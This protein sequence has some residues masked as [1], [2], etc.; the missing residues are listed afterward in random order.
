MLDLI[1]DRNLLCRSARSGWAALGSFCVGQR[2]ARDRGG[3]G[4]N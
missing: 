1:L 2:H 4:T 3:Y